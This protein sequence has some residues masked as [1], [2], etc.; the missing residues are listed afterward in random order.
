MPYIIAKRKQQVFALAILIHLS[1]NRAPSL[2][3]FLTGTRN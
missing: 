3:S 2:N 1:I